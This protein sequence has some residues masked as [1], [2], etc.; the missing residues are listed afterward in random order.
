MN[1]FLNETHHALREKV[2]NFAEKYVKPVIGEFEANE[3][4]PTE[5]IRSLKELNLKIFLL[6]YSIN[7]KIGYK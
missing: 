1:A 6:K 2:R 5:L 3:Q 7:S 4:F